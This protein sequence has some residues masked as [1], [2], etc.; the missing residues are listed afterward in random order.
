MSHWIDRRRSGVLLHITSLPGP[1]PCGVLGEEAHAFVDAIIEGGF[2]VW[3]FLPLGPTHGHGSPYESLSSFAGNP[4][5]LDLREFVRRGWLADATYAAVTRGERPAETARAEAAAGFWSQAKGDSRL[6][7]EV[8]AFQ[9]KN[10]NWL[11]DYAI[12]SA[13]KKAHGDL[14][15]WQWPEPLRHREKEALLQARHEH[16]SLIRQVEFEQW[17]F[18]RQWQALKHHAETRGVLLFGDLPIYASHDSADVWTQ[19]QYFTVDDAGLCQEVAGV[20]PDYFSDTGQRWGNPLYRWDV[21]EADRFDWWVKRVREQL[22]RM[23]LLRIDHFRGLQAYWAIPGERQDGREGEWRLAPG[24]ALLQTL[25]E[26]LGGLPFVA[27]D[28]GLITPEVH[29]LRERFGLP[30]MK[31][32]QFAFDGS[33]DNPYLPANHEPDSVVY[34]G[35]HDNDTTLGWFQKIPE[36]VRSN[37]CAYVDIDSDDMPWPLI[38]LALSSKALLAVIPM[39]DLLSLGSEARLNTPAT[40]EGNWQWRLQSQPLGSIWTKTRELNR[41]YDR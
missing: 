36:Q 16:A 3:Q 41:L 22:A 33:A 12:F 39:Q 2:T 9:T 35:T 32:L 4:E 8:Q 28:L 21:L 25:R 11:D 10:A 40:I 34:T 37:L 19:Q 5:L 1:L 18:A 24:V 27:E 29:A 13:F 23:H 30:G 31:I 14:P 26:Q 17:G 15:W 6:A 20:P 7:G 38:R